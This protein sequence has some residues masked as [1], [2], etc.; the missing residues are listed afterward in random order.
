ML[1]T[2]SKEF[3]LR[4]CPNPRLM[5]DLGEEYDR[6]NRLFFDGALPELEKKVKIDKDKEERV[7]YP[8][9][10][11]NGRFKNLWGRY[12]PTGRP[13]HGKIELA[14]HLCPYPNCVRST[15]L[16]EMVHKFQCL[17]RE[18]D[19]H[20]ESFLETSSEVNEKAE[21]LGLKER[22]GY[23]LHRH[24]QEVRN[25][26]PV[27]ISKELEYEFHVNKDLDVARSMR[28]VMGL[29]TGDRATF[30]LEEEPETVQPSA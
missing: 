20:G 22:C 8:M 7:T 15:L 13:G 23:F 2:V 19:G 12:T 29:V 9:L 1:N 28:K 5:Y 25:T 3:L 6:L 10:R 16:H 11:W 18:R 27:Y 24:Y 4:Y 17:I 21:S 30:N 26:S 14:V